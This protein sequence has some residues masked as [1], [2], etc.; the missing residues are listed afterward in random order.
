LRMHRNEA[1]EAGFEVL[2]GGGQGRT[3]VIAKTI[4]PFLPKRHLLSYLEAILRIYNQLGRR[5]N[6]YKSRI[7]ILVDSVGVDRFTQLVEEAWQ[8][9]RDG[10]LELRAAGIERI[11]CDLPP[12]SRY[13][14][15]AKP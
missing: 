5:D 14:S 9:S 7:K 2:V 11:R 6:L 3:P 15:N 1:G 10:Y 8:Q 12:P 4:R 13:S